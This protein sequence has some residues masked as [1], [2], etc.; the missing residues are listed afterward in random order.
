MPKEV[1]GKFTPLREEEKKA[2]KE[3]ENNESNSSTA[4][5]KIENPLKV[6]N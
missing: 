2:L 3:R 6:K 4:V 5:S 1:F